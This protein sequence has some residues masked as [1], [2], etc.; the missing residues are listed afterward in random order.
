ML[1]FG[2]SWG[3]MGPS[4]QVLRDMFIQHGVN[5]TVRST[6][7]SGTTACQWANNPRNLLRAADI[8]FGAEGPDYVWFTLGGN[9]LLTDEY[10]SCAKA[11]TSAEEANACAQEAA[12]AARHC[13]RNLLVRFLE[14]F[15][16]AEVFQTLYDIPC[17][18]ASCPIQRFPICGWDARC[19]SDIS[20][21]WGE[22]LALPLNRTLQRYTTINT[23]GVC[24][25]A[26]KM[27]GVSV[28]HPNLDAGSPCDLMLWCD[29]PQP[30]SMASWAFGELL[31]SE[32]FERR[33]PGAPKRVVKAPQHFTPLTIGLPL[34]GREDVQCNSGWK[35]DLEDMS[36]P[37]PPCDETAPE[38]TML[39]GD[40]WESGPSGGWVRVRVGP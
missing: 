30:S 28:G 12:I 8:M 4:W 5:A 1:V 32:Y 25:A 39:Y 7:V 15:Q 6:A 13:N 14:V 24:Q 19:A 40:I 29:H 21:K 22:T 27:E 3:A 11:A 37:P 35:P 20:V 18:S 31:W 2:D 23:M 16:K 26:G 38:Y 17:I 9:D 34:D 10:M 36:A 33:L